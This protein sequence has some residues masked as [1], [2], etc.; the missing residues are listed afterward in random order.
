MDYSLK[1]VGQK[2]STEVKRQLRSTR[3]SSG[4][5]AQMEKECKKMINQESRVSK[6]QKKKEIQST[7]QAGKKDISSS[8][9]ARKDEVIIT[10]W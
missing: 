4:S 10:Y 1:N 9:I 7:V 5:F 8:E 2:D 6:R 3:Q